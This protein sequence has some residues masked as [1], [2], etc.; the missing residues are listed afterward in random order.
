MQSGAHSMDINPSFHTSASAT[1][2]NSRGEISYILDIVK[3]GVHKRLN[4]TEDTVDDINDAFYQYRANTD[5]PYIHTLLWNRITPQEI[6]KFPLP[7]SQRIH[8]AELLFAFNSDIS[9]SEIT[10]IYPPVVD[11]NPFPTFDYTPHRDM[12][13]LRTTTQEKHTGIPIGIA[14]RYF[15]QTE[16]PLLVLSGSTPKG[17]LSTLLKNTD[18]CS[19]TLRQATKNTT[20]TYEYLKTASTAH[21]NEINRIRQI[22]NQ[23]KKHHPTGIV[24]L[25]SINNLPDFP[26]IE[27]TLVELQNDGYGVITSGAYTSTEFESGIQLRVKSVD[28]DKPLCFKP[29][30]GLPIQVEAKDKEANTTHYAN[31]YPWEH[32]LE[33]VQYPAGAPASILD[34]I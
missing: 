13:H 33:A 25:L 20:F 3:S 4:L 19:P 34:F 10:D 30:T 22:I 15:Y 14:L 24:F 28:I 16:T 21:G 1:F 2:T 6:P 12:V 9:L 23:F 27:D 32:M 26:D 11:K 31:V 8:S 18:G 5:Y 17:R 29:K 7:T